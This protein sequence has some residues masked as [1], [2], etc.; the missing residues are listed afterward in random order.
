MLQGQNYT[1]TD[2]QSLELKATFY[3]AHSNVKDKTILY[4]HGGG[5]VYGQRNDLPEN[6]LQLFLENGYHFLAFDYPLAP[7]TPL[8]EIYS[9]SQKGVRWFV[10]NYHHTLG[11]KSNDFILFGRSAGAYLALLLAHDVSLLQPE[12][13]ISFY[14]YPSLAEPNFT[15]KSTYY[16][17]YQA[18]PEMLVKKMVGDKPLANGPLQTHYAL[19]LYGRQSG[20]WLNLLGISPQETKT[21][22]LTEE[23]LA[24]LPPTFIAHSREDQDVP[25][26][27]GERL[28]KNIPF[29]TLHSISKLEHDFDRDPTVSQAQ[30]AY[31]QLLDWLEQ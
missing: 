17:K 7:E 31:Q 8:A 29:S 2:F 6:Y 11:I 27:I 24:E 30:E 19:Y 21:F 18:V 22:S 16:Q 13:I 20:K 9:E 26:S 10:D 1:Y 23:E 14:G 25:Y 3:Q 12:K 15:E 5:L 4:F 28:H